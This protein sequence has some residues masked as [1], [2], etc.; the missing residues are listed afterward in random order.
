MTTDW[1][2]TVAARL[3]L[4]AARAEAQAERTERMLPLLE[5]LKSEA[6]ALANALAPVPAKPRPKLDVIKGGRD[7]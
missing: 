5:A 1:M 7:A 6:A 3:E 4:M 2:E